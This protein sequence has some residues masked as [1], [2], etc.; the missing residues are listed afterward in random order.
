MNRD[1]A[2]ALSSPP[3]LAPSENGRQ[4]ALAAAS[5]VLHGF[6]AWRLWWGLGWQDIRIRYKR[7][8]LGPLWITASMA[9]TFVAMGLLFSTVLKSDVE[10]YLPYLAF[11]MV[12]WNFLGNVASDGPQI[13]VESHHIINTLKM[14][15]AVHVLRCVVRNGIIFAH[16]LVAAV[17]TLWLLG[18]SLPS[19]SLLLVAGLPVLCLMAF[20]LGMILAIMGARFRDLGPM[21]GMVIQLAFFLTPI[22]WRL[23]DIPEHKRW[24]VM[25]NPAYHLVEIVRAPIVG[26]GAFWESLLAASLTAAV[27]LAIAF[28]LLS[29]FRRRISYWL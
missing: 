1:K 14:P 15:F 22:L 17:A 25:A 2:E 29:L 18:G 7:T 12:T 4:Q 19:S 8:Y 13:F 9:A 28:I 27:S 26:G 6:L 24:W 21:I 16:N 10:H 5:D 3:A 23:E 20:S 11:G